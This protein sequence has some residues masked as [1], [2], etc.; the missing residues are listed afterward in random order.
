MYLRP[1]SKWVTHHKSNDGEESN[2]IRC[3]QTK[4]FPE[5]EEKPVA[6]IQFLGGDRRRR[7]FFCMYLP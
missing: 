2:G 3:R 6:P 4:I 7:Y 5:E 1:T